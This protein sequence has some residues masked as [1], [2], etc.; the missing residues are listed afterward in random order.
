M[1]EANAFVLKGDK[2]EL[3]FENV[4]KIIPQGNEL[5]L[6]DIFG[7]RRIIKA[8]IKEMAL[9]DHKILLKEI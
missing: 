4:D 9:V 5:I 2:E 1:C 3:F 8:T 7:K 6:E